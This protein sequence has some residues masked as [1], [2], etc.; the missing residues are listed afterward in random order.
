MATITANISSWFQ[1]ILIICGLTAGLAACDVVKELPPIDEPQETALVEKSTFY[2][3]TREPVV[4]DLLSQT[5]L[6]GT[7]SFRIEKAPTYG[8]AFFVRNSLVLY[9]PDSTGVDLEDSFIY[10]V[11]GTT[12]PPT[13]KFQENRDTI[14]VNI[15]EN[16][17]LIPCN[18]GAMPD[19]A[20]AELNKAVTIAVLENDRF[21]NT[22]INKASLVIDL[23]PLYGKV[24]IKEGRVIYTPNANFRGSDQFIY[25][26][27]TSGDK[28]VCRS[29]MVKVEVAPELPRCVSVLF[30]DFVFWKKLTGYAELVIDVL[31]NDKICPDGTTS[32]IKVGVAPKNGKAI[33]VDNKIVYV[34]NNDFNGVEEFS[35]IRC[36]KDG[37]NC[38]EGYIRVEVQII[39]PNCKPVAYK[40][41]VAIAISKPLPTT[42]NLAPTGCLEVPILAND[43]LCTAVKEI[44][45]T[46]GP[47]QG[48]V[49]IDNMLV[50]YCPKSGYV[51]EDSFSYEFTD[52]KGLKAASSVKVKIY[53]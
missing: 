34:P 29:A 9:L 25:K 20:I 33:V 26:I 2:T 5:N 8:K 47:A 43:K 14:R 3:A 15:K 53:K 38:L 10:S 48:R 22:N 46:A 45:I 13:S 51:G 6:Q 21:C 16:P 28:P 18:A 31:K 24:E 27:C 49:I 32:P 12:P 7:V 35:Y 41:E 23:V 1:K 42:T 50:F 36:D 19:F 37:K 11:K 40:D 39:D 17:A 30:A 52:I 44:R 4:I